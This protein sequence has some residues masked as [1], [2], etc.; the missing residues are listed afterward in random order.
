MAGQPLPDEGGLVRGEVVADQVH[1]QAGRHGVVDPDQE[2]AEFHGTVAAVQGADD[3]AVSDV[4]RGEQAGRPVPGVVMAA[5]LGHAGHHRQHRLGPVQRLDTRFLVH[6]QH[7][8]VLRRVV[9]QADHIDDLLHEE[10]VRRQLER[11]G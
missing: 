4:E 7:H 2:L 9:V 3:G 10:R 8:R 1:V 11:A 6:A 5:A